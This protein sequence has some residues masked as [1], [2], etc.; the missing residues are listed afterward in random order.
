MRWILKRAARPT[1]IG[2]DERAL[3]LSARL[4]RSPASGAR[5]ALPRLTLAAALSVPLGAVLA[6]PAAAFDLFGLFGSEEEPPGAERRGAA[7]RAQDPG[8]RRFRDLE[9][10]L[11]DTSTLHRLRREPPPDGEGLVRRAEADIRRLP[12]AL[13]GY[14]Y[15][16]GR[17]TVR[18]EEVV[19]GGEA[20]ADR[21]R[22]RRGIRARPR[23]GPGPHRGR[24]RAA[25]HA[26]HRHCARSAGAGLPGGGAAA[27]LHPGRR[28]HPGALQPR[29]SPA[30]RRSSTA[31]A[32]AATPSPRW[33]RAIPSWTTPPTSWT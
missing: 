21:R 10:T 31:S 29:C 24:C 11:E 27:A 1:A 28:R 8:H 4:S 23:P 6:E 17:V 33:C 14:G 5:H 30:R 22:P 12:D 2:A 26:P 19:L 20:V 9:K 32:R 25:L 7:L 16:A 18:I 13:S 3:R 15:Y